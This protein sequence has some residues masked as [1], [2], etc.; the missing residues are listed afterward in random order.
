MTTQRP[1][2]LWA[3]RH[4]PHKR[5]RAALAGYEIV[6]VPQSGYRQARPASFKQFWFDIWTQCPRPP[7]F[8]VLMAPHRLW[9]PLVAEL[10]RRGVRVLQSVTDERDEFTGR[11]VE[12]YLDAATGRVQRRPWS[13]QGDGRHADG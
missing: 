1:L 2:I 10:G 4:P 5:Y 7:D 12:L 13:P 8:V 11:F 3:M 9:W 6:Q